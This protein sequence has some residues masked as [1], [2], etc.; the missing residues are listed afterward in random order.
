MASLETGLGPS[1]IVE[2]KMIVDRF[3][4]DK[5]MYGALRVLANGFRLSVDW[6]LRKFGFGFHVEKYAW[7]SVY[8]ELGPF[9]Y[10]ATFYGKDKF[11]VP[12]DIDLS[13]GESDID[14]EDLPTS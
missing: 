1:E 12:L 2:K 7:W 10:S 11:P 8:G 4:S 5:W 9:N 6:D 13:V 14:V 3:R